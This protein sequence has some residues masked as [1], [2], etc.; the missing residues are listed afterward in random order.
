MKISRSY[1]SLI[2][3]L[4]FLV[5]AHNYYEYYNNFSNKINLYNIFIEELLLFIFSVFYF[6]C[7]IQIVKFYYVKK[8]FFLKVLIV[9]IITWLSYLVINIFSELILSQ[10]IKFYIFEMFRLIYFPKDIQKIL[11]YLLSYYLVLDLLEMPNMVLLQKL[12]NMEIL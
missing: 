12:Q 2:F 4:S 8:F 10:T 1:W 6:Y 3:L 11:L 7:F 9:V 5:T